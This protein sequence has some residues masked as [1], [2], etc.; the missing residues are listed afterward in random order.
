MKFQSKPNADTVY[1]DIE[2]SSD[3]YIYAPEAKP[4][5]NCGD[6]THWVSL[7]FEAHLCSEECAD[8]KWEEYTDACA[9]AEMGGGG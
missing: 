9:M 5:W 8:A 1:D 6:L 7:S 4:C 2:Y 3:D